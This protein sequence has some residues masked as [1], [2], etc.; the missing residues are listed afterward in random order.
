M[1]PNEEYVPLVEVADETEAHVIEGLLLDAGIPFWT[2]SQET[3]VDPASFGAEIW[4]EVLVPSDQLDAAR[5]VLDATA[6]VS[7]AELTDAAIHAEVSDDVAKEIS[8]E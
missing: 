3:M 4:G 1:E 8:G 7:E 5:A 6:K 2:R